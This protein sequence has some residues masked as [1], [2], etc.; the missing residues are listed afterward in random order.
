MVWA[1]L[2]PEG[3][4]REHQARLPEDRRAVRGHSPEVRERRHHV[5]IIGFAK[6]VGDIADGAR[7]VIKFFLLTIAFTWLLLFLYS[8]SASWRR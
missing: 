6:M 4:R 7:S 8:M 1:D 5:H 2:I 3:W